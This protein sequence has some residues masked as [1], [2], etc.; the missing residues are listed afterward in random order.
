MLSFSYLSFVISVVMKGSNEHT[1]D[2]VVIVR[3]MRGKG[4]GSLL[5]KKL[6]EYVLR[7]VS[8][9]TFNL[10]FFKGIG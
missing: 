2:P 5:M 1:F 8:L 9:F 10:I 4:L 7:F 3:E 6:E